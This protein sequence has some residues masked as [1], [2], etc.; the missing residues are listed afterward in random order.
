[1]TE[2]AAATTPAG[3]RTRL[4]LLDAFGV[5]G[6]TQ[7]RLPLS[8]Q[9]LVAFLALHEHP[10]QRAYVA[11]SLW[12]DSPDERAHANLRSALWRIQRTGLR[13]VRV[14]GSQLVLDE[15]VSVDLREARTLARRVVEDPTGVDDVDPL[16]LAGEL[17]PDWYDDWLVFEREQHRQLRLHA[18]EL[19]CDRLTRDG[20]VA[21]ALEAGLAAV[22]SE[23][24]RESAHRAVIRAHLAEGN[25][26]E[27]IR[28]YELCRRVLQSQLG[29]EPSPS[30]AALLREA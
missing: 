28:Q 14:A 20:R 22:M 12:L 21:K 24:L 7:V 26:A 11:C 8:A 6:A 30:I 29:I 13:L 3:R 5:W 15:D 17:L 1:M 27:A 18:L 10:L 19:L 25:R 4:T 23:P 9:R 16:S 2:I